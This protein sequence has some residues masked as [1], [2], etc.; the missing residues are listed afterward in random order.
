MSGLTGAAVVGGI[1]AAGG[2]ASAV[3]SSNAA[4]SA[5]DQQAQGL[6]EQMAFQERENRRAE[7]LL[8]PFRAIQLD[9]AGKLRGLTEFGNPAEEMERRAMTQAI[10]RK[11]AA[12]GLLRSGSQG[13]HL[14]DLEI[15]LSNRR[16]NILAALSGAG[17]GA[18][19]QTAGMITEGGARVGQGF[20]QIGSTIGA[21][22][23]ARGNAAS[24]GISSVNNAA[25]GA[26]GNYF[27][28]QLLNKLGSGGLAA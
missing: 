12:Q 8:A 22:T 25:Q 7:A 26:L 16:A 1:A 24:G 28:L 23:I 27:Q 11:L 14:T 6:R 18:A 21:G 20:G 15:G 19:G 9:A 17:G 13:K 4:S 2:I 5:A 3:I 10:Q